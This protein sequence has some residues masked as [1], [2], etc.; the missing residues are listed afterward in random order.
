[1]QQHKI[2]ETSEGLA[3]TEGVDAAVATLMSWATTGPGHTARSAVRVAREHPGLT[4]QGILKGVLDKGGD[5]YWVQH[6]RE[7]LTFI[8]GM[9]YAG[10]TYGES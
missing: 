9:E 3:G 6:Y 1:M 7:A 5:A 8:E 2:D 10:W 4:P